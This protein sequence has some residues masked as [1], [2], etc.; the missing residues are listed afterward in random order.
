MNATMLLLVDDEALIQEALSIELTS[1][2]F[3]MVFAANGTQ[4]VA[5]L[6]ANATRF[7]AVITDI[8]LGPGPDG[9]EI[10]RHAR[11]LVPDISIIYISGD[12]AH[13][14]SS[15]GVPD[16]VMVAKPFVIAQLVTTIEALINNPELHR[17]S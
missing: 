14:W 11:K 12:S 7:R 17:K 10:G 15:K 2:G 16:S 6:D 5:E 1:A 9:W 4:A 13:E 3:A 8:K